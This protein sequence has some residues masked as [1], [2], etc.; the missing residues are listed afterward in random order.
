SQAVVTPSTIES[1]IPASQ[2][3]MPSHTPLSHSTTASQ[4][5]ISSTRAAISAT[6]PST[7]HVIGF[8]S[9]AAVVAQ[10]GAVSAQNAPTRTTPMRVA[11]TPSA[12]SFSPSQSASALKYGIAD[13]SASPSAS[14]TLE[15]SGSSA[16]D[17]LFLTICHFSANVCVSC[18]TPRIVS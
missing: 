8:A 10:I 13:W 3:T 17:A 11:S 12:H 5:A 15:P 2:S 1:Q 4:L 16:A 6:M 7:I 18:P 9:S 14:N